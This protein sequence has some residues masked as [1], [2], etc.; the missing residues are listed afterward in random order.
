MSFVTLHQLIIQPMMRSLSI[1][2]ITYN[3]QTDFINTY[4]SLEAFRNAGGTHIVVNGGETIKQLMDNDCV[5][6]EEPDKGIYDALN[7]GIN[8]VTTSYFMLIHSGDFLKAKIEKLDVLLNKMNE[9]ELD[10][11]LNDCSI[12]F[13]KTKRIMKSSKWKPWMFK[14]GVQPPHPPTIYR[15]ESMRSFQYELKH[16]V[17]ADFKYFEDLFQSNLKWSKG[18]HLL[19]HMSAGGATSSGLRSFFYVN[20]QFRKLKGPHTMVWFALT[21]PFLKVYQMI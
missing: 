14:F 3:N 12:E 21:R 19:I 10:F 5:L 17:I 9:E 4:K 1:V 7:K 18:N 16:P 13:G 11:L 8:Q 20:K 15:A 2:T 6:L